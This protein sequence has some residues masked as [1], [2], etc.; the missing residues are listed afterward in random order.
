MEVIVLAGGDRT[1]PMGLGA[2]TGRGAG[3]CNGFSVPGYVK[4]RA[5][6]STISGRNQR[7]RFMLYVVVL[8]GFV[9]LLFLLKK[10]KSSRY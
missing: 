1:G 6:N 10:C 8:H 2:M 3:F 7:N 4:L 5:R 9:Y